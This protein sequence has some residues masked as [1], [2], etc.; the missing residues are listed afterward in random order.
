MSA[1]TAETPHPP[2]GFRHE[3]LFYSGPEDFLT[4]TS[5]F[6]RDGLERSEAVLVVVGEKKI[7]RLR[8][9]LGG[10]ADRV[11]F[12]DMAGVGRNPGRIIAAWDD[13]VARDAPADRGRRGVGEPIWAGR[14][15]AE[16]VECH[17]NEVLLN[18]SFTGSGR[19]WLLCPYDVS[20][21]E[22]GVVD[23]ARCTHPHVS[24]DEGHRP[25]PAYRDDAERRLTDPLP[26]PSDP[27]TELRFGQPTL[28]TLRMFVG[29]RARACGFPPDRAEEVVLGVDEIASN[30]IVHGGGRGVLRTW[31]DG[32]D[33]V[34]EVRDNGSIAEPLVGRRR[35][36]PERES[37]YGL[38]LANQLCDLVQLRS[39]PA[40][41]TVRLHNTR[42][43]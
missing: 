12:E 38:W 1:I 8:A 5:A 28:R 32:D 2:A 6:I 27:V 43:A 40:G 9:E 13:F 35:P 19:F 36:R 7:E 11:V 15:R 25:S 22:P 30:S 18:R 26:P 24:D 34:F 31:N 20:T 17:T 37:G 3:A 14:T 41:T 33:L 10:G 23:E 42:P 39:G 16:V 21:L 29:D 4:H